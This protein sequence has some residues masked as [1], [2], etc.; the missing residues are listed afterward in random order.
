MIVDVPHAGVYAEY[1]RGWFKE[2][3]HMNR[4]GRMPAAAWAALLAFDLRTMQGP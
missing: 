4:G 2:E 3:P 1:L